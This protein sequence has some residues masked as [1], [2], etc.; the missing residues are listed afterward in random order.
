MSLPESEEDSAAEL[1]IT[2]PWPPTELWPNDRSYWAVKMRAKQNYRGIAFILAIDARN[3]A[4]WVAPGRAILHIQVTKHGSGALP[5]SD[6]LLAALKCAID[7]L[8]AAE[9]IYDDD[10]AHLEIGSIEVKRG[11]A[12][13][14]KL[15]IRETR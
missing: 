11:P 14:V 12:S 8:K 3:L 9:V 1:Q 2:L 15:T 5:D 4:G 10:P 13:E 7:S 6:N